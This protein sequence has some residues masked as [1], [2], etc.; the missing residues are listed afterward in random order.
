MVTCWQKRQEATLRAYFGL[1]SIAS[2]EISFR[3]I[4]VK[5]KFIAKENTFEYVVCQISAILMP[6]HVYK[7]V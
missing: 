1:V 3:E 6:I 2:D 4:L 5:P 7:R